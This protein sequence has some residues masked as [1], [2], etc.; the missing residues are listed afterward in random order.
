M[1]EAAES[2]DFEKVAHIVFPPANLLK[3]KFVIIRMFLIGC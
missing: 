2:E 1:E 3:S